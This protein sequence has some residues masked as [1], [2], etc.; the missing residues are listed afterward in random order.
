M[1]EA[2]EPVEADAEIAD[3]HAVK[4]RWSIDNGVT[5]FIS[6][7]DESTALLTLSHD[8]AD[9]VFELLRETIG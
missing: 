2:L 6:R 8:E 7:P 4:V 3:D 1:T 5:I 9:A